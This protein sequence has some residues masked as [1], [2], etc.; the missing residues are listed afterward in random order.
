MIKSISNNSTRLRIEIMLGNL[1][2]FKCSYCFPD[3]NSGTM[4]WPD[5]ELFYNNLRHL[6]HSYNK[7]VILYFIGGEPTIW[8]G[9]PSVMHKLKAEFDVV[10]QI[11]T[12]GSKSISWWKRNIDCFDI[13]NVSIHHE[14]T[15]VEHSKALLDLLYQ[16]NIECN[17]DVLMDPLCF[18]KCVD[19]INQ[20]TNSE[21]PFTVIAKPVIGSTEY[22]Q[23][24]KEYL[25]ESV[26]R[27]PEL[28]WYKN[29]ARVPQTRI[30]VET[31]TDTIELDNDNWFHINGYNNFIGF[32]CNLGL[33][34]LK[35]FRDGALTGNCQQHLYDCNF[36]DDDFVN[37]FTARTKPVI[38]EQSYCGCSGEMGA[39]KWTF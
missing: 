33:D 5:E 32:Y 18:D 39:T 28:D 35:I 3:S 12:N 25:S 6:L 38:C 24:Q 23:A 30:L 22:T 9:L 37:K 8:K 36:Y 7:P 29:A 26:K 17:A 4:P 15:K 1:C 31:D 34:V 20:L 27:Y 13:V 16:H 14:Y 10:Y 2:N 11:S 21:Y 19:I